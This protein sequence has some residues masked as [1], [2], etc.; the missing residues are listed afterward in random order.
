MATELVGE[1]RVDGYSGVH[2][3]ASEGAL[4]GIDFSDE[5]RREY[6][7]KSRAK[8]V[9]FTFGRRREEKSRGWYTR[10]C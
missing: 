2:G 10:K 9:N 3:D 4:G 7:E 8:E 6:A 1:D 5:Q